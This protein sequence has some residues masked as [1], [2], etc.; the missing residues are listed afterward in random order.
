[1]QDQ[2]ELALDED[3]DDERP[4]RKRWAWLLR[5]VW[6]MTTSFPLL[7]VRK[8]RTRGQQEREASKNERQELADR[9]AGVPGR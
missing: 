7:P 6:A 5:P 4:R 9:L 3:R 8:A 1:V 2:L